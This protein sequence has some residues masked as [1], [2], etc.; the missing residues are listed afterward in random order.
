MPAVLP[1]GLTMAR[2]GQPLAGVLAV[3][4]LAVP[5]VI[6]TV[7][8]I[9]ALVICPFLDAGRQRLVIRLLESLR[10]WTAALPAPGE[11]HAGVQG[12][13]RPGG[14][15]P[16]WRGRLQCARMRALMPGCP[17]SGNRTDDGA[18]SR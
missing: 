6:A 11:P 5:L 18:E 12:L 10:Q 8:L 15:Y 3:T 17:G 16:S 4:V 7:A 2:R 13:S 9:P 1:P 14:Q